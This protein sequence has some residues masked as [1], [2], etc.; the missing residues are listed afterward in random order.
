[1][2]TLEHAWW[3]KS[4]THAYFQQWWKPHWNMGTN[5]Q[6]SCYINRNEKKYVKHHISEQKKTRRLGKRK[7]KGHRRDWKSQKW[8]WASTSEYDITDEQ[9]KKHNKGFAVRLD[10][11]D[12]QPI[13]VKCL[14]NSNAHRHMYS[15]IIYVFTLH[16]LLCFVFRLFN[17]SF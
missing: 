7:Y 4:T 17:G 10:C 11:T 6:A 15:N 14:T 3:D 13:N 8:T 5:S 9:N 2:V 1:M 16:F 12:C